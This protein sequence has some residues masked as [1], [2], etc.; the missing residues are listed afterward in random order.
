[1][2]MTD[3]APF[4]SVSLRY[5]HAQHLAAIAP[6][7]AWLIDGLWGAHHVGV[8]GGPPKTTKTWLALDM[9]ISVASGTPCLGRFTCAR[10]GP[11]LLFAAEDSEE[12]LRRRIDSLCASRALSLPDIPL[13]VITEPSLRLDLPSYQQKLSQTLAAVKPELLI[14]DPFVRLHR[15]NENDA[16][17]VSALLG[18][19]REL[20]R[21]HLS[22]VLLVHHTRKNGTSS[23]P[24]NSLRGS[25]DV[26]A[27]GDDM[28]YLRRDADHLVL[29]I[30]HRSCKSPEPVTLQLVDGD[31]PHL[32]V[33]DL[34]PKSRL[35]IHDAL[36]STLSRSSPMTRT[37][38]RDQLRVR[39]HDLGLALEQLER[40]GRITSTP[41]GWRPIRT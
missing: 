41:S 21:R 37:A 5:L 31:T 12:M 20:Q 17:A 34:A 22:A 25:S 27:W 29:V 2:T 32:K 24:G 1:M 3:S 13:Y 23:S 14:L 9:A 11:V 38:L 28:L 18:Y 6:E 35:G 26:H 8:L 15:Q 39:N 19:L 7:D 36:L 40:A 4:D 10:P 30:E 33:I 16:G